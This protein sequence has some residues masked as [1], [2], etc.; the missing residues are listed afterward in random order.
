MNGKGKSVSPLATV[1]VVER[2]SYEVKLVLAAT[3]F[4]KAYE[5]VSGDILETSNSSETSWILDSGCSYH[6]CPN[7]ELFA[8]Y[9]KI[10]RDK[11]L[12]GNNNAC[13]VVGID[14][15]W[16]K[17]FDRII[18]TLYNGRHVLEL[19]KNPIS[20]D[21]LDSPGYE[22]KGKGGVLKVLNGVLVVMKGMKH[23]GRYIL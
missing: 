15:M 13:K 14:M 1:V 2:D 18:K 12:M 16:I 4:T 9:E 7:Q 8:T 17:M 11:I 6:K 5:H 20:L 22:Y 21:T 23:N 10:E 3:V 19:K